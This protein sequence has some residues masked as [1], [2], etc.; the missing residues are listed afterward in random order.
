MSFFPGVDKNV[1]SH[2]TAKG[3]YN[4]VLRSLIKAL[5]MGHYFARAG[6]TTQLC[7]LFSLLDVDCFRWLTVA[8]LAVALQGRRVHLYEECVF[9]SSRLWLGS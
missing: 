8:R 2:Y 1:K 4:M 9:V 5:R 3:W 6:D 7:I